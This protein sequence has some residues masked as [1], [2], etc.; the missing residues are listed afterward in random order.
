MSELVNVELLSPELLSDILDPKSPPNP[1]LPRPN[2]PDPEKPLRESKLVPQWSVELEQAWEESML[3]CCLVKE[4]LPVTML[5]SNE[6]DFP[7]AA[8]EGESP[9]GGVGFQVLS[10]M[11]RVG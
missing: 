3:G 10:N 7:G 1:G 6:V 2:P 9:V 5:W 4:N 8:E 11:D